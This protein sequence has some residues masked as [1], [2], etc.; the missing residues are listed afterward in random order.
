M[1]FGYHPD[2]Y[3]KPE[4]SFV[5][6]VELTRTSSDRQLPKAEEKKG[7]I[8]SFAEKNDEVALSARNALV[9]SFDDMEE[10]R[11]ERSRTDKGTRAFGSKA[12]EEVP[13]KQESPIAEDNK[14]ATG[15]T[16]E[17]SQDKLHS[18]VEYMLPSL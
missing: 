13:E 15:S 6:K 9:H 18:F 12:E 14:R 10:E 11:K 8:G 2:A 4:D 5:R 17:E 7:V 16:E 3:W 1:F